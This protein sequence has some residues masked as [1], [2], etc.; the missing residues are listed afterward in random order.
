MIIMAVFPYIEIV[1]FGSIK[2]LQ[3]WLD[4]GFP[5]MRS[6]ILRTKK[7]TVQQYINLYSGPVYLM[8]FKYS[9]IMVQ[10]FVSFM[11]GMNIPLLF[12]I[13]MFGIFNMYVVER[14]CLA[15]YYRQPPMYDQKLNDDVLSIL[16]F[17]PLFMFVLGYWQIGNRQ[18]FFNDSSELVTSSDRADPNHRLFDLTH[19]NHTWMVLIFLGVI[20]LVLFIPSLVF[21]LAKE[22]RIVTN[23]KALNQELDVDEQLANYLQALPGK[24]Q[25]AWY[26]NEVYLRKHLGLQTMPDD[27]MEKLRTYKVVADSNKVIQGNC[28]N[29]EILQNPF[30]NERFQYQTIEARNDPTDFEI[31]DMVDRILH[32]SAFNFIQKRA[33]DGKNLSELI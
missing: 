6:I 28:I 27:I 10:V 23:I 26:A 15:Y 19:P 17:A 16:R 18:M 7:V 31:C 33:P 12:P 5:C 25:K 22:L 2:K 4:S 13:A 29:Y 14:V 11:Y 20:L 30:Y 9:S 21:K 3:R 24:E 8:H 32:L 1:M